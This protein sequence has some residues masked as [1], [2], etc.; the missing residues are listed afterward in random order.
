MT[1]DGLIKG[2]TIE[3][4]RKMTDDEL[5]IQGW[6]EQARALVALELSSG[7][8]IYPADG[9]AAN[10]GGALFGYEGGASDGNHTDDREDF[11]V[12]AGDAP[13]G[14]DPILG[15]TVEAIRDMTNVEMWAEGW[16]NTLEPPVALELSSGVVIYPSRD[17]EGNGG[18][19]LV[20]YTEDEIIG[21]RVPDTEAA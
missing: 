10:E 2:V 5:E 11:V 8:V 20:G 15:A 3:E 1:D 6:P 18:G 21:V 12:E 9:L 4:A 17:A 19:A 13:N 14:D 7:A 16:C